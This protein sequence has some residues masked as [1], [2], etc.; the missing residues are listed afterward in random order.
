[1]SPDDA[2]PESAPRSGRPLGIRTSA[3]YRTV[4]Q[5]RMV[6]MLLVYGWLF[7]VEDGHRSA[8]EKEVVAALDQ[9]V[10]AGLGFEQSAGGERSFDPAEVI[11]FAKWRGIEHADTV[12]RD[13]LTDVG[14]RRVVGMHAGTASLT[15]PPPASALGPGR[16]TVMLH[17]EF[18]LTA[19]QPGSTV[20]L[21]LPLPLEDA[22]LRELSIEPLA[23]PDLD[24]DFK[25][26]T[27]RLDA[28]VRAP[29][30]SALTLGVRVS[31]VAHP[32]A[33]TPPTETLS[34]AELALYTRSNEAIVVVSPRIRALAAR[35]AGPELKPGVAVQRF[36]NFILDEFTCGVVHYDELD[37]AYPTDWILDS[38]WFDCH[39][40]SAL[41]VALCR[42]RG[43]AARMISGYLLYASP[44]YH[45]W[46]EV[47]LEDRWAPFDLLASDL[48]MRG[49]DP[50]WRDY[51][52]GALDYRMKT[53][54]LPRTFN[55]TPSVR[56]PPAWHQLLR[57]EP[58]G[59]EIHIF[60]IETGKLVYRD[61]IFVE[62][63]NEARQG[64]SGIAND[65][66][67]N[68]ND[69]YSSA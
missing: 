32:N 8:S 17:R 43:I 14:R 5:S 53:Q 69:G 58:H 41:L 56:F 60:D 22:A 26:W 21:R 10:A 36:W 1:M 4:A 3:R 59:T 27:G 19:A 9:W 11:N 54:C 25:V 49:R 40:G 45:Y 68:R 39:L 28:R 62:R 23:P 48:S 67:D 13:R 47:R 35:L 34:A 16:F 15:R 65:F 18:D 38:G 24:V 31:F 46:A 64:L 29:S 51:F 7:D 50:A 30:Q 37:S 20:L 55:F 57:A 6:E 52:A 42:A 63:G 12:W 2:G 44:S 61:R 66:A 33:A